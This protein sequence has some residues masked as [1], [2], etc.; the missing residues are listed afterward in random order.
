MVC[1]E[2]PQPR[3]ASDAPARGLVGL[4]VGAWRRAQT[5]LPAKAQKGKQ[6]EDCQTAHNCSQDAQVFAQEEVV[7]SS[8]GVSV[9]QS[10]GPIR[11]EVEDV[12]WEQESQMHSLGDVSY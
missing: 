5:E 6:Q 12:C 11:R 1:A 10:N 3:G 2:L 7:R 4:E 8:S 9:G